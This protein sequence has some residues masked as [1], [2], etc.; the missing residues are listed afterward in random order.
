MKEVIYSSRSEVLNFKRLIKSIAKDIHAS[1]QLAWRLFVRNISAL[2]RQTILGYAWALLPPFL[3]ALVFIYL[4]SNQVFSIGESSLPYPVFIISGLVFWQT[5]AES[6]NCPLKVTSQSANIL[7]RVN[8]QR[9]ALILAGM[10]E[11]LFN[12][13]VRL[14]LLTAVLVW[15]GVSIKLTSLLL[16]VALLALLAF[17]LMIGLFLL[18]AGILYRD[19]GNVLNFLLLLWMFL[20]PVLYPPPEYS[21]ANLISAYNPVSTVLN[22]IREMLFVGEFTQPGGF[23]LI[24]GLSV[25]LLLISWIFCRLSMPY[26][27]ER[28]AA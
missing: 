16:P 27:I 6:V 4:R 17:G 12:L 1:R 28:L 23:A 8:F 7:G 15:F 10:G 26:L 22:T 11:V 19:I 20:S 18:P 2:Y 21:P 5:F 3:T 24:L 13:M 25:F 9:E 14:M